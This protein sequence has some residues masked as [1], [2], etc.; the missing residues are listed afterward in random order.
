MAKHTAIRLENSLMIAAKNAAV[1]HKRTAV[2]QIEY[3]A[4]LGRNVSR[5]VDPEALIACSS[6]LAELKVEK[7][8][9]KPV[10]PMDVFN[11]LELK[12]NSGELTKSITTT[13]F[14]YKASEHHPGMLERVE[15]DGKVKVGTF[16]DGVFKAMKDALN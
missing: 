7:I 15:V 12:R 9:A 10:N 1:V 8:D 5:F 13:S 3:W 4:E 6:G 16:K 14:R 2:E 11:N